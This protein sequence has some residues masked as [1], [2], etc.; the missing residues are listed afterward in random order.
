MVEVSKLSLEN[1]KRKF[2]I[3]ESVIERIS[4]S[5]E[6][7]DSIYYFPLFLKVGCLGRNT[8]IKKITFYL[9]SIIKTI[10]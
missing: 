1:E 2:Q 7:W 5:N 4:T 3:R 8:H 10:N 6:N 9:E